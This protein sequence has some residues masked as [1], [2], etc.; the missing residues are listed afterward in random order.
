[1]KLSK[2]EI[3]MIILLMV[4]AL[5]FIEYRFVIAPSLEQ[6]YALCE[7]RDSVQNEVQIIEQNMAVAQQ[8]E[9]RRDENLEHIRQLAE[10]FFSEP[11]MDALL[12]RTHDMILEKGLSPL[13]Y[14]LQQVQVVPL[15][16]EGYQA[17][18]LVYELKDLAET[19]WLLTDQ[20]SEENDDTSY[21]DASQE[22]NTGGPLEHYQIS[23]NVIGTYGQLIDYLHALEDLRRS[24]I[25]SSMLI[26]PDEM[27]L[28]DESQ[29][30]M[31]EEPVEELLTIQVTLSYYGLTKLIPTEDTF[32]EWYREPFVP[33]TYSP[34]KPLP[35]PVETLP[36]PTGTE[37][38]I[39]E[40]TE[41]SE[42]ENDT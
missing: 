42:T 27:V 24:L 26:S 5:V 9:D 18:R 23:F 2:R 13:Q 16:P 41:T 19:Y 35:I 38:Q 33:V 34:F 25:V 14:Q 11:K 4:V 10:P 32:N 17:N 3:F 12:V 37:N 6:Y 36:E 40:T 20:I 29:P 21:N 7:K 22:G 31:T 39:E 28:Q 30:E 15:A 1:M 8:N